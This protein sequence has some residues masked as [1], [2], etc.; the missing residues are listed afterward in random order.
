M[1]IRSWLSSLL[2]T[3]SRTST[4]VR[5]LGRPQVESLEERSLLAATLSV[6]DGGAWEQDTGTGFGEMAVM[7]SEPTNQTVTVNY[8]TTNLSAKQSDYVAASGTLTF[9]PGEVIKYI[10]LQTKG[11]TQVEGDESFAVNLSDPV[12]AALADMQGIF[13]IYNDDHNYDTGD[14]CKPNDRSLHCG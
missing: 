3:R 9:A 10:T 11:D 2:A 6:H 1:A 14:R 4:R 12:N 7:L 13:T 5:P 8:K